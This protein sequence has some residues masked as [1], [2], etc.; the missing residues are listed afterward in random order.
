MPAG[1]SAT[2]GRFD[3]DYFKPTPIATWRF[4]ISRREGRK[5]NLCRLTKLRLNL[6][7]NV[8]S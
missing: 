8:M 5:L 7:G 2:T 4:P 1:D 3:E 6:T